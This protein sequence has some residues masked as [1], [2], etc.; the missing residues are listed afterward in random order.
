MKKLLLSLILLANL[1]TIPSLYAESHVV[2]G[3][4]VVSENWP[5]CTNLQTW[6][7][8]IMRLENVENASETAQAK[9]F[10]RWLRLFSKM[11]TG[12]MLQAH[13][14]VT[15]AAR[16]QRVQPGGRLVE[17]ERRRLVQQRAGQR[18]LLLHAFREA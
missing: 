9:V 3:P 18:H 4:L 17:E 2:S 11:A 10:F 6:M 7:H 14:Q 12:G 8:D 16:R 1:F 5:E 13:D 15:D